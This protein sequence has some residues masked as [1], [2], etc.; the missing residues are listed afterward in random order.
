AL[1]SLEEPVA[2]RK[3]PNKGQVRENTEGGSQAT[4]RIKA[5]RPPLASAGG[6]V[7]LRGPEKCPYFAVAPRKCCLP[8]LLRFQQHIA[9]AKAEVKHQYDPPDHRN[10]P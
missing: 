9:V 2:Q 8:P 5:L 4:K 3:E 7:A 1:L 10:D 6:R